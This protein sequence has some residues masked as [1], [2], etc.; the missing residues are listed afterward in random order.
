MAGGRSTINFE[1]R[2]E[3]LLKVRAGK[4]LRFMAWKHVDGSKVHEDLPSY[5]LPNGLR[6]HFYDR[7]NET[8][9]EVTAPAAAPPDRPLTLLALLQ[10]GGRDGSYPPPATSFTTFQYHPFLSSIP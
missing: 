6:G 5:P 2:A 8:I 4:A 7:G 3:N 9:D 10:A 1:D